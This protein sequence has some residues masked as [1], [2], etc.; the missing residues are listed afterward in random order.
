LR[1]SRV[2]SAD[3][4]LH[5]H[6]EIHINTSHAPRPPVNVGVVAGEVAGAARGPARLGHA[7]LPLLLLRFMIW[8]VF[9]VW[10]EKKGGSCVCKCVRIYVCVGRCRGVVRVDYYIYV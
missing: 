8:H 7:H 2:R 1:V 9:V 10:C 6:K 4:S 3:P 5:I